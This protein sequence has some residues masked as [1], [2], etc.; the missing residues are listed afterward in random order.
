M[1]KRIILI[2]LVLVIALSV[3]AVTV[4]ANQAGKNVELNQEIA[5]SIFTGIE[6]TTDPI[7]QVTENRTM[8]NLYATGAPGA[9]N[10]EV[11]GGVIPAA[12]PSGLCPDGTDLELTFVSG[13]IVE[14]FNDH[15]LLFYVIDDSSGAKNALCVDFEGPALGFFDYVITGGAGRFEGASGNATVEVTAWAVT[16]QLS[17]EAGTI[18]G[19][20]QLP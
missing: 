14:T 12:S 11:V 9:A 8:L 19:T 20:V 3:A 5:G 17:G 2:I 10:L 16:G 18:R 15:S 13:G 7:N 1:S 6:V 4:F